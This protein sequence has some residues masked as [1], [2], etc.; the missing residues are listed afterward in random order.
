MSLKSMELA[1]IGAI[2]VLAIMI[3]TFVS[4]PK[5]TKSTD[6]SGIRE[7]IQQLDTNASNSNIS[8]TNFSQQK[9]LP[10]TENSDK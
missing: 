7:N 4:L 8:N 3:A 6:V 2:I 1:S 9:R 10:N 5:N